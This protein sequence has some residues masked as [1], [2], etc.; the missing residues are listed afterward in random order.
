MPSLLM[1]DVGIR[2]RGSG[3]QRIPKEIRSGKACLPS[4]LDLEM[5]QRLGEAAQIRGSDSGQ[6][7]PPALHPSSHSAVQVRWEV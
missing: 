7:V 3:N 6:I 2:Y 1:K 5:Y 4:T